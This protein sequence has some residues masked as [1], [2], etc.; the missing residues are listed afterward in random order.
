VAPE[1]QVAVLGE[2]SVRHDGRLLALSPS[3]QRLIAYLAL[4]DRPVRRSHV[5]STLW[6]ETRDRQAG[7]NLRAVLSRLRRVPVPLVAAGRI[8]LA[9]VPS[10]RVDLRE[11]SDDVLVLSMDVLPDWPD[12]WLIA[13]RERHRQSRLHALE[14]LSATHREAGRWG[15]ALEAALAAVAGEPLRETAHR[16]VIAVHLGEGNAAEALRQYDIYRRLLH[17]ELGLRPSPAIRQL[18]GGLLGRP[19]DAVAG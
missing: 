5:A 12:D 15:L 4:A 17:R 9:L 2:L 7:A 6:L 8:T 10:A 3:E 11:P 18:I 14:R 16:H 1:I 13:A 19:A